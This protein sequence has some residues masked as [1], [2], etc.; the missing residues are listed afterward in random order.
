MIIEYYARVLFLYRS[1]RTLG[2]SILILLSSIS[3]LL[4][5][6][7]LVSILI[8]NKLKRNNVWL[9]NDQTKYNHINPRASD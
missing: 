6:S 1:Q 7:D 2:L 3:Y 8:N 5:I 4:Q 9:V